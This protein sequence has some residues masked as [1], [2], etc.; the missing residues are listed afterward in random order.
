MPGLLRDLLFGPPETDE[1]EV[2]ENE[3]ED[4]EEGHV[5]TETLTDEVPVY[6]VKVQT[7]NGDET[8]FYD[9]TQPG[10]TTLVSHEPVVDN[11]EVC[12][13]FG[14]VLQDNAVS[15][16]ADLNPDGIAWR[17]TRQ[18]GYLQ[19]EADIEVTVYPNRR[20]P[21]K[22]NVTDVLD[23]RIEFIEPEEDGS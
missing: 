16:D 23:K 7:T 21:N 10:S 15:Y 8:T 11:I 2:E 3:E 20:F 22:R 19:L 9:V 5:K 6:Q 4:E 1:E 13:P 17:V 18:T 14:I 12:Q